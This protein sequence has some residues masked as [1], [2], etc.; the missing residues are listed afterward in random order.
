MHAV[1]DLLHVRERISRQMMID[2]IL[3]YYQ[4]VPVSAF[5]EGKGAE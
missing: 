3:F 2:C 1:L 5:V 4:A